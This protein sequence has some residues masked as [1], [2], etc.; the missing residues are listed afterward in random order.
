[1]AMP[2]LEVAES[3]KGKDT[4]YTLWAR[5]LITLFST[6]FTRVRFVVVFLSLPASQNSQQF[7][8]LH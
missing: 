1:M 4:C 8:T 2:G 3:K 5:G 6:R 7:W